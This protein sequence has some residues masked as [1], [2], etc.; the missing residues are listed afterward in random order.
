MYL[1]VSKSG[2]GV[3]SLAECFGQ[4]ARTLTRPPQGRQGIPSGPRLHQRFQGLEEGGI[5]L[6]HARAT[7][8]RFPE[9]SIGRAPRVQ[10]RSATM[11][12]GPREPRGARHSRPPPRPRNSASAAAIRRRCLS[13][14]RGK[15]AAYFSGQSCSLIIDPLVHDILRKCSSYFLMGPK[16][17]R[18]C[19]PQ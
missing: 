4:R 19:A 8:A 1:L 13:S 9:A 16:H 10:L 5:L 17:A 7:A 12:G 6:G 18:R 2:D 3:P 15:M 11:N 14:R